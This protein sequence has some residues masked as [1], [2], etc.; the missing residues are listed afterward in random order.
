MMVARGRW[1]I[2]TLCAWALYFL[3]STRQACL[4]DWK[5]NCLKTWLVLES[6]RYYFACADQKHWRTQCMSLFVP[7]CRPKIEIRIQERNGVF[8]LRMRI[9]KTSWWTKHGVATRE[10]ERKP[11]VYTEMERWWIWEYKDSSCQAHGFSL[12][13]HALWLFSKKQNAMC[14][15]FGVNKRK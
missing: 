15:M 12:S 10:D 5:R 9:S 2:K 11:L 4:S 3:S 13:I 8:A 7:E 6:W 14:Y 1:D